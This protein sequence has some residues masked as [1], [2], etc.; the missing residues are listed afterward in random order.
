MGQG[1]MCFALNGK[2]NFSNDQLNG[3]FEKS[4]AG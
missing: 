3:S 4:S 1:G 2:N